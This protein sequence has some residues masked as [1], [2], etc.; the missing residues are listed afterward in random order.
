MLALCGRRLTNAS[1]FV[2]RGKE[3]GIV[4]FRAEA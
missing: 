1:Q 2:I 3:D 4:T